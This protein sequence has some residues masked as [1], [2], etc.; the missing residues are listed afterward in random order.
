[1]ATS[2]FSWRVT[3]STFV[4]WAALASLLTILFLS[5]YF[6]P[7]APPLESL[8]TKAGVTAPYPNLSENG[9]ATIFASKAVAG[10]QTL[11]RTKPGLK[12]HSVTSSRPIGVSHE[13]IGILQAKGSNK[14][15]V[16]LLR[17]PDGATLAVALGQS[18][19]ALGLLRQ[20]EGTR[21]EFEGP[22]REIVGLELVKP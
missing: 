1:M 6:T 16:A 11:T 20:V 7:S 18:V 9:M 22:N 8:P 17:A 12:A 2:K 19:P 21:A 3:V 10:G 15:A 5:V 4:I 14:Q 13:L